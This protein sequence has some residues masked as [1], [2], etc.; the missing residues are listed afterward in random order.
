MPWRAAPWSRTDRLELDVDGESTD[1]P[2]LVGRPQPDLLLV[3][4]DDLAYAKIRL[5]QRSLATALQH[6]RGFTDSL[7]R[8]LV[9]GA[10]WDMTRDAEMSGRAFVDLVLASLPG[11]TDST[12]LRTLLGQLQ[13]TVMLYV[14]PEHREES[15]ARTVAALKGLAQSAEPG[16]DAQLQLVTA[17]AGLLSSPADAAYVGALLQGTESL[18]GLAIDT[19]MRWTLL[20][21]LAAAG[22]ATAEEIT[23]ERERD[24]TSTGRERE[25]RALAARPTAEAKAAAWAAGVESDALPNSVLDAT[26]QGFGRATDLSLL[27]P[28][29]EKYHA[30]LAGIWE[31]RTHAIAESIVQQYYPAALASQGLLDATQAWLDANTSAPAALVRLVSENR[32]SIARALRAQARDAQA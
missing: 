7:P 28:Y 26:S 11:E 6:P 20:T 12:L 24:N 29:V 15:L 10:A 32:D 17:Y 30:M 22:A 16:S 1:I 25:A 21:S 14:A 31:Q 27:E 13:T 9:L 5:D 19:E 2:E 18:E 8:A 4:D 23:A 3:N